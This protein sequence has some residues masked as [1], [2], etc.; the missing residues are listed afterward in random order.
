MV[1]TAQKQGIALGINQHLRYSG[2]VKGLKAL[3]ESLAIGEPCGVFVQ[4][5]AACLVTNGIHLVDLAA[6][7][8]GRAPESVISSAIGELINPRSPELMF[9]GGT[10]VWSFGERKEATLCFSNLS[11]VAPYVSIYYRDAV[12]NLE[13]WSLNIQIRARLR[14]ELERYP[15]I[16][17][18]GHPVENLFE[19]PVPGLRSLEERT[20]ILLDEIESGNVH[21]LPPSLALESLGACIGALAAGNSCCAVSL[22]IQPDSEL[23]RTEWPIS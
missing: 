21:L 3:S 16:T 19:G 2:L 18:T 23:G 5:G 11:S 15:A 13:L 14:A 1:D 7:V 20:T 8:F 17:R 10:A 22:P 12:V 9:Y 4:G 6:Q